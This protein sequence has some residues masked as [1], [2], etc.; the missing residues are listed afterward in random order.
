MSLPKP[1][2]TQVPNALFVMFQ[3]MPE[4][5]LRCVLQIARQ[6]FGFH[7]EDAVCSLDYLQKTTGLSRQGVL[8]GIAWL[9]EWEL[10]ERQ[11]CGHS[12][13]YRVIVHE[14]DPSEESTKLTVNSQPSGLNS[15]YEV[16]TRKKDLK[17]TVKKERGA[18]A[19]APSASWPMISAIASICGQDPK[20][21]SVA[22]KCGR[23]AKELAAVEATPEQV[24]KFNRWARLNWWRCKKDGTL[25]PMDLPGNWKHAMDWNG[26]VRMA[27]ERPAPIIDVDYLAELERRKEA[28]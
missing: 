7:R 22:A 15:V 23:V 9:S 19:P 16:D 5:A 10:I 4:A 26:T 8:N 21:K 27:N 6:T 28:A 12:F 11:R 2:Y 1:N 20:I 25:D 18:N 24:Q 3:Q 17:K 13:T 14:V